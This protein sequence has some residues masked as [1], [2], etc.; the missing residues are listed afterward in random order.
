MRKIAFQMKLWIQTPFLWLF[1][2]AFLS[3]IGVV[4]VCF[5]TCDC[6]NKYYDSHNGKTSFPNG[7]LF[8]PLKFHKY[9]HFIQM[10]AFLFVIPLRL[11]IL[12]IY[13]GFIMLNNIWIV[14]TLSS[15]YYNYPTRIYSNKGLTLNRRIASPE[16]ISLI[17]T[18]LMEE[19]PFIIPESTLFIRKTIDSSFSQLNGVWLQQ[20]HGR[21]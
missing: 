16:S 7:T 21:M 3:H 1:T 4:F 10:N 13:S 8:P 11:F 12:I 18:I 19:F 2:V 9:L 6:N 20:S 15:I 14:F 5:Y 17:I